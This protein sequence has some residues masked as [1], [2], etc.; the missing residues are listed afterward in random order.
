MAIKYLWSGAT[1]A[2]D[3]ST[4]TNAYTTM[5]TASAGVTAGDTLYV[6]HDHAESTNAAVSLTFTGT[7]SNL[8]KVICINRSTLLPATTATVTTTG[9]AGLSIFGSVY[10]YGIFFKAGTSGG[11]ITLQASSTTETSAVQIYESCKINNTGTNAGG[12]YIQFHAL[13]RTSLNVTLSNT[14]LIFANTAH[15]IVLRGANVVWKNTPS[16]LSTGSVPTT[17]LKT[18]FSIA[19]SL[20]IEDVDLSAMGSTTTLFQDLPTANRIVL[21]RVRFGPSVTITSGVQANTTQRIVLMNCGTTGGIPRYEKYDK[22]GTSVQ[23]RTIVKTNGSS[24]KYGLVSKKI[25]TT[26]FSSWFDPHETLPW[27]VWNTATNTSNTI[28][29][30]GIFNSTVLPNNDEIWISAD[31]LN[32][33]NPD[34]ITAKST[35]ADPIAANT[36]LLTDTSS[37]DSGVISRVN[38]TVYA[39]NDV[40][41]TA[42]NPGRI[43]F[44]TTAGTSN[45]IEPAGYT[46]AV[47]GSVI[48]DG[49]AT[50]TAGM[51]F[52]MFTT[53]NAGQ[54]GSI[55]LKVHVAKTSN[56]YYIDQNAV[57][58]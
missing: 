47:D 39:L 33:A 21:K 7:T 41:K 51:R 17:F 4:F 37:W 12:Q 6:A 9:N 28:T 2:G 55:F 52:K 19:S 22:A 31:Y 53:F 36:T 29:V 13:D 49:T 57:I 48:T 42:S 50:F 23:D 1:G 43:F 34:G 45:T 30:H 35:I 20:L 56:T 54:V 11:F 24:D 5:S 46:T 18:N 8:V 27:T 10:F 15:G 38:S 14:Q 16:A 25:T 26:T 44:C 40:V 58:T 32:T 3:G